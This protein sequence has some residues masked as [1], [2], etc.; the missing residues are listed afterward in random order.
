MERK[1]IG[2]GE[3]VYDIIFKNYRPIEAKAGGS[4]LNMM[5]SLSRLGVPV[6]IITDMVNDI[7]GKIL[8]NFFIENNIN[9]EY[10][11]WHNEGRSRLAL[12][13]LN[14]NNDADYLFYKMQN[15]HLSVFKF[16]CTTPDDILIFGSYYS[17]KPNIRNSIEKILFDCKNKDMIILF[18]PNFRKS[19][20]SILNEVMPYILKNISISSI[21]KGSIE[22]FKLIFDTD[23]LDKIWKLCKQNGCNNLII[24]QGNQPV[25]VYCNNFKKKYNIPAIQP[26]STIGAGD[27]F[28]SG[29]AYSLIRMNLKLHN[30]NNLSEEVWDKIINFSIAC[31]NIV[32]LSY[33][34]YVN[35][36]EAR[37]LIA[38]Y[39]S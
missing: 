33:D 30:I 29:I 22:D 6:T 12:A 8:H 31:S 36:N 25:V 18:D 21:T 20:L 13:F 38:K 32:C 11:L 37:N 39:F 28:M 4:I 5:V 3:V 23:D 27:V 14:Q 2:I 17:I 15:E 26:L 24:T 9:T 34:N 19:H 16:P 35:Q 10:I 7:V 1:I